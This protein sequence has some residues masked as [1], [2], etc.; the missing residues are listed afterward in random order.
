MGCCN[1]RKK[2]Y[3]DAIK[4]I[5]NKKIAKKLQKNFTITQVLCI[6]QKREQKRIDAVIFCCKQKAGKTTGFKEH[7]VLIRGPA[8][9]SRM[10]RF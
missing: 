8:L 1:N 9:G 6:I 5:G 10:A 3:K 7:C 2:L 4:R